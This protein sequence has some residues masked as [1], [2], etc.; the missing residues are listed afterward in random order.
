MG[1]KT[2]SFDVSRGLAGSWAMRSA[3]K[4]YQKSLANM[5]INIGQKAFD[6]QG[7]S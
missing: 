5:G 4:S 6:G 2:M 1:S 7:Y 3:G